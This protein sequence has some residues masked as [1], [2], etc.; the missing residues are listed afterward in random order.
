MFARLAG[1]Y[2]AQPIQQIPHFAPVSL[3]FVAAR[4]QPAHDLPRVRLSLTTS[5]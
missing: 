1:G 3:Q 4:W 5:T 2:P